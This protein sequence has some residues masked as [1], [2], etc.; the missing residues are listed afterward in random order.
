MLSNVLS[1]AE[2]QIARCKSEH[3][4]IYDAH[5]DAIEQLKAAHARANPGSAARPGPW[6][7]APIA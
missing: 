1:E 6:P 5:Y 2:Y 4:D 3:P 7:S